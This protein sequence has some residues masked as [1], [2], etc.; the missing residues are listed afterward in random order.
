MFYDS[1]CNAIPSL[2]QTGLLHVFAQRMCGFMPANR[3]HKLSQ[4]KDFRVR[5]E[6]HAKKNNHLYS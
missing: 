1:L 4:T 3:I 5:T 6:K 2:L